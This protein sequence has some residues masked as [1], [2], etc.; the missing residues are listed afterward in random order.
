MISIG[1]TFGLAIY[2]IIWFLTLFM[3]LPFGIRTQADEDSIEP[4]SAESAPAVPKMWKR[5]AITT[6]FSFV[7]YLGVYW[8]LTS[9]DAAPWFKDLGAGVTNTPSE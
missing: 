4:G 8:L 6:V 9:P 3:V 2:G 5:V 7:F 1:F